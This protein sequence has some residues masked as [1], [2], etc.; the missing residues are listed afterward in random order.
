[1]W[2]RDHINV[3]GIRNL[4]KEQHHRSHFFSNFVYVMVDFGLVKDF[5]DLKQDC[6]Q[7]LKY[8]LEERIVESFRPLGTTVL[9]EPWSPLQPV[10][11]ALGTTALSEH[12]PPLQPVSTALGTTA[13]GEAWSPL[14]PVSTALGTT[15]LGEAWSPLQPVS[16]AL[17]HSSSG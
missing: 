17:G 2:S 15:A 3:L 16:T 7:W 6:L 5:G 9:G 4:V 14:Q 1:V 11:T 10:S 12:W 8:L 13:L